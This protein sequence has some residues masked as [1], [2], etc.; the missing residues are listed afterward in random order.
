ML[1]Y[2]RKWYSTILPVLLQFY[3]QYR[4][5]VQTVSLFL[6]LYRYVFLDLSSFV[7]KFA[8]MNSLSSF[9]MSLR[10]GSLKK[11]LMV[12]P[13][14]PHP[15]PLLMVRSPKKEL[16]F[17]F[18]NRSF[19]VTLGS[20][21]SHKKNLVKGSLK[22]WNSVYLFIFYSLHKN[23]QYFLDKQFQNNTTPYIHHASS[24]RKKDH[25]FPAIWLVE[26]DHV[27]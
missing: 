6:S 21:F 27:S 7:N 16:I 8:P 23:G 14:R 12:R 3:L 13:L 1:L 10:N 15:P 2:W 25:W 11:I 5:V 18:L 22:S 9:L 20:I 17:G 26:S 4:L 24:N 19:L